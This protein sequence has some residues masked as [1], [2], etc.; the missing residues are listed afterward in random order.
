MA[1]SKN[2][3]VRGARDRLIDLMGIGETYPLQD[4]AL[5]DVQLTVSFDEPA[6]FDIEPG[7]KDVR[8]ELFED[9]QP[10]TN[11]AGGLVY[12]VNGQGDGGET[13]L[14]GPLITLDRTF[15]I[16]ARKI[17][18][19]APQREAFLFQTATVK[20]GLNPLLGTWIYG[21]DPD[22]PMSPSVVDHGSQV[23]VRVEDAQAGACYQLVYA[24]SDGVEV[25]TPKVKGAGADLTLSIP[26]I[27]EDTQIQIR[28]TRTFDP[29]EG[30]PDLEAYLGEA[31]PLPLELDIAARRLLALRL[32]LAVRAN[33]TLDVSITGVAL[34]LGEPPEDGSPLVD[35]AGD[36]TVTIAGSQQSVSYSVYVRRLVDADFEIDDI[37]AP[38]PVEVITVA[39]PDVLDEDG[40]E[41]HVLVHSP[42]Y[43]TPWQVQ[44]GYVQRVEPTPGNGANLDL[45]VGP[46]EED[47]VLVIRADKS[48]SAVNQPPSALQLQQAV[49]ALPR[50]LAVP[51]LTL[52]LS[53]NGDGTGTLL[54]T[55][56]QPGVFYHLRLDGMEIGLPAYF[57]QLDELDANDPNQNR[58]LGQ[59]RLETDFVV[60]QSPHTP[61]TDPAHEPPLDPLVEIADVDALPPGTTLSVMAVKARTRTHWFEDR[62]FP[63]TIPDP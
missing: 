34:A 13:I 62:P 55:G 51:D 43:L 38:P 9:D 60:A 24:G 29:G 15:Q 19:D 49:V 26:V 57:H 8:Y 52:T 35:P 33:P 5:E 14:V 48:H 28:V 30:R 3:L 4:V 6:G 16:R 39:I 61:P 42:P 7:Q 47:S 54:A 44:V 2:T 22:Q 45:T 27:E 53:S 31:L 21:P 59:L 32:P 18:F 23:D 63:I 50:P 20:V 37:D 58:G 1:P 36:T 41:H 17:D 25:V 46:V 56:G 10:V 11:P 12:S 40:T